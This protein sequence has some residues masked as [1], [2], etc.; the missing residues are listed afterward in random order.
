MSPPEE[1]T[2]SEPVPL[3]GQSSPVPDVGSLRAD[4]RRLEALVRAGEP[5][6]AGALIALKARLVEIA[7]ALGPLS[8]LKRDL[9]AAIA[10]APRP[11]PELPARVDSLAH[12]IG[13]L[14][15]SVAAA[16]AEM[17]AAVG[18]L[19]LSAGGASVDQEVVA[20]AVRPAIDSLRAQ[21]AADL[22]TG[23]HEERQAAETRASTLRIPIV[24]VARRIDLMADAV[25][26]LDEL[27]EGVSQAGAQV[28]ERL[29]G[30]AERSFRR[31]EDAIGEARAQIDGVRDALAALPGPEQGATLVREHLD[32]IATGL[33]ADI[34][35]LTEDL[36]AEVATIAPAV[37]EDVAVA[38]SAGLTASQSDVAGALT[39]A[40]DE[41]RTIA[42]DVAT[43]ADALAPNVAARIEEF[44]RDITTSIEEISSRMDRLLERV[45]QLEEA[46]SRAVPVAD[47]F[48]SERLREFF[49]EMEARVAATIDARVGEISR[50]D[51]PGFLGSF[52]EVVEIDEPRRFEKIRALVRRAVARSPGSDAPAR[53]EARL[54]YDD[55]RI[56]AEWREESDIE[57]RAT[58]QKSAGKRSAPRVRAT[59]KTATTHAETAA[60]PPARAK[61]GVK[62]GDKSEATQPPRAR[63]RTVKKRT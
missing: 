42:A 49:G 60:R 57:A 32:A 14:E 18:S 63:P 9:L 7:D 30:A 6:T 13:V 5:A 11:D 15:E 54:H 16:L 31:L 59:N 40:L 27:R 22:R 56:S 2:G 29:A 55:P 3:A 10:R 39:A 41:V 58:E 51:N 8:D 43:R 46:G 34:A 50:R 53:V 44:A 17:R 19:A 33:R 4:V 35:V 23:L 20:A 1:I 47:P 37:R 45:A 28:G 52:G 36:H 38:T 24:D 48:P 25:R 62:K 26:G 61:A 21:W 12:R